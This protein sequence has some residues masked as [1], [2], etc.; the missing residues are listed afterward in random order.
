[1]MSKIGHGHKRTCSVKE[2]GEKGVS[3]NETWIVRTRE[4]LTSKGG[5]VAKELQSGGDFTREL[6]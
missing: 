4:D 2:A 6:G 1:M 3:L 5:N